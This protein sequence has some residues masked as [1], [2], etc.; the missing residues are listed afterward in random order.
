MNIG[1]NNTFSKWPVSRKS[2]LLVTLGVTAQTLST[3]DIGVNITAFGRKLTLF[4]HHPAFHLK[5]PAFFAHFELEKMRSMRSA[6]RQ[7]ELR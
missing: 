6:Q 1:S 7:V 5:C 3:V 4:W 2:V